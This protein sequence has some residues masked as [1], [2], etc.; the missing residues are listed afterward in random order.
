MGSR[1][2]ETSLTLLLGFRSAGPARAFDKEAP[3]G[4][5]PRL[6]ANGTGSGLIGTTLPTGDGAGALAKAAMR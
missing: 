6:G 4:T 3:F 1:F 2:T 5:Q